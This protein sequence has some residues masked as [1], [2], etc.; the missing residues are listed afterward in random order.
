MLKNIYDADHE[1]FLSTLACL[2]NTP[3]KALLQYPT[4]SQLPIEG[5][6]P[7]TTIE[8]HK[9]VSNEDKAITITLTK[10]HWVDPKDTELDLSYLILIPTDELQH[11]VVPLPNKDVNLVYSRHCV[12]IYFFKTP[13]ETITTD[14]FD[15]NELAER[16]IQEDAE[17]YGKTGLPEIIERQ[18]SKFLRSEYGEYILDPD[19]VRANQLQY[20]GYFE[21]TPILFNTL[22]L[23][24]ATENP[25]YTHVWKYSDNHYAFVYRIIDGTFQF[26]VGSYFPS[27]E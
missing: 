9:I 13:D 4:L 8:C 3:Y 27:T 12:S 6:S 10:F 2:K 14:I 18:V 1:L 23:L 15:R 17:W 20:L 26:D 22:D 25:E 21:L 7:Y 24:Y 16:N 11:T 19:A 5:L